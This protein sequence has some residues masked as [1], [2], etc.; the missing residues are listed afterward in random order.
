MTSSLRLPSR[1]TVLSLLAVAALAGTASA[2]WAQE[3]WKPTKPIRLV[4]PFPPG[5]GADVAA[6]MVAEGMATR[7]G[8]SVVVENKTGAGGSI[9]SEYVYNAAADGTVVLVAVA[10]ALVMYPHLNKVKFETPKFV[11]IGGIFRMPYVL[12]GRA[13]LPAANVNELAALMRTKSLSIGNAGAGSSLHILAGMF[14]QAAKAPDS[15]HVPFQGAAP[16]LQALLGGQIDLMM[17]PLVSAPQYRS[18]LRT[19]GIASTQ[20]A[21]SMKDVPTL[22]EQGYAVSGDSWAGL[23]APPGTPEA[24]T[25]T[26]GKA[27]RESVASPEMTKKITDMSVLPITSSPAEFAKFYRDEYSKWGEVIKTIGIKVE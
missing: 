8:Q 24:I 27:L 3:P 26:I 18:K 5:G 17:V 13:D 16:G 6:R 14:T 25:A 22:I 23:V 1:R 21:D 12:M 10:D 15:L 20:R 9:G 2:P 7:L 4:V 11:P 19:Y